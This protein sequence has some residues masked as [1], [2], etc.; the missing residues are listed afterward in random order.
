MVG[1]DVGGISDIIQHEETGL[2]ARQKD[3]QDIADQITRLLSDAD[4]RKKVVKNGY[5]LINNQF[6]WEVISDRFI[7]TYREALRG[8]KKQ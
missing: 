6:S 5:H 2:L 8:L 3:P 4:L 7:E 1:S